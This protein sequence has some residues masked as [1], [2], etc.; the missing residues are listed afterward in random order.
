MKKD[1]RH[2]FFMSIAIEE[3][4]KVSRIELPIGA[5]V[6]KNRKVISL[7][8]AEDHITHNPTRHAEVV[9]IKKACKILRTNILD[10]CMLYSTAE[11]C[12]MC[13]SVI[14]QV[15]L[16]V[17]VF[18]IERKELPVRMRKLGIRDLLPDAGY[19]PIIIEGV[20]KN[21]IKKLF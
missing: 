20:L 2:E 6:V 7:G 9:A 18:G 17:I 21:T 5:I 4:K 19:T 15:R 1:Q 3:A 8:R 16:P 13:S 10:N 11:P 12:L 14:F